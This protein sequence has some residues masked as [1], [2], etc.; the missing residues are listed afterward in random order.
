MIV[1][2]DYGYSFREIGQHV[3]RNQATV[4]DICYSWMQEKLTV[5]RGQSHPPL[6]TT[7]RDER[8]IVC[9]EVMDHGDA[10]RTM[11]LQIQSV[12]HHSVSV[13]TIQYSGMSARR[14]LL[15]LPLTG[16]YRRLYR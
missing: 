3:G 1:Y 7:V 16:N 12:T 4:M 9:M 15:R 13:R 6:C 14:P 11:T 2:R 10:S 8:W 5:R